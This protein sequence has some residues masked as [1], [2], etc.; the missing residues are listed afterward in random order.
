MGAG[1]FDE[2]VGEWR[3][4]F[5]EPFVVSGRDVH[6]I[7]VWNSECTVDGDRLIRVDLADDPTAD[8][9]RVQAGFEDAGEGAF[10]EMFEPPFKIPQYHVS[11]L[12]IR[13]GRR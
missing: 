3:L 9:D 1:G 12:T 2:F 4:D 7:V 8:F 13:C 10:N 5:L 6:P 11:E